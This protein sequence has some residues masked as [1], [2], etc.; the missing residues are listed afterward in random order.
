MIYKFSGAS[1]KALENAEK[2]A[3]ELGHNLIGSEHILYG[4][5]LEEEGLGY[6]ILKKQNINSLQVFNK[7]KEI[8][9]QGNVV[10]TR[11]EGFTPRTRKIIENSFKETEK[12]FSNSIGTENLLLGILNDRDN[13]AYKILLE[14]DADIEKMYDDIYKITSQIEELN[15]DKKSK[16]R[17]EKMH[18]QGL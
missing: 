7:I 16:E 3:T 10:L 5:L 6:K 18:L 12:N 17:F 2:L 13:V 4:I 9:G 8:I 11:T 15:K 14:L 1:K